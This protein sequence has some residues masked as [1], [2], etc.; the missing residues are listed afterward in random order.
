MTTKSEALEN[1]P[2]NLNRPEFHSPALARKGDLW[3]NPSVGQH[4]KMTV[5]TVTHYFGNDYGDEWYVI[6]FSNPLPHQPKGLNISAGLG[7]GT[8]YQGDSN[9]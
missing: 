6:T 9:D 3:H 4:E 7:M 2:R 8:F 5:E 1:N